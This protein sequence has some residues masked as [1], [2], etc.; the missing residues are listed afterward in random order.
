MRAAVFPKRAFRRTGGARSV[1]DGVVF[2]LLWTLGAIRSYRLGGDSFPL[3]RGIETFFRQR[4]GSLFRM[5]SG[6]WHW[7][8]AAAILLAVLAIFVVASMLAL[9]RF[10]GRLR[11]DDLRR[12]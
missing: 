11:P 8:E 2:A 1:A 4:G 3:D 6:V 7:A 10:L 5:E 12:E 9:R